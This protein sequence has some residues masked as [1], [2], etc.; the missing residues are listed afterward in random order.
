M[1]RYL[2]QILS[3]SNIC[4]SFSSVA[5]RVMCKMQRSMAVVVMNLG[6]CGQRLP[7]FVA[8][9]GFLAEEDSLAD[10]HKPEIDNCGDGEEG[11]IYRR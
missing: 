1:T 7:T 11:K 9:L 3:Q 5:E 6:C 8:A 2:Q 4:Q 10:F